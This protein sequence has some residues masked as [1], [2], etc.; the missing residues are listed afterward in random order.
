MATTGHAGRGNNTIA[1][2]EFRNVFSRALDLSSQL[3]SEDARLPGP[4]DTKREFG[5]GEHGS[6]HERE[7]A[8]VA[9]PG[10]HRGRV[11]GDQDL[12]VCGSGLV[13]LLELEKV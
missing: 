6:G 8:H 5:E 9:V 12:V 4:S 1:R 11:Y 13:Y 3:G 10:R 2:F 7:I